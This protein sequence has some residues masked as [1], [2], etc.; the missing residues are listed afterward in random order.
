MFRNLVDFKNQMETSGKKFDASLVKPLTRYEMFFIACQHAAS[1]KHVMVTRYPITGANSIYPSK[2]HLIT[3]SKSDTYE[4]KSPMN[5]SA[6]GVKLP[7]FPVFGG[8]SIDSVI[9]HPTQLANLGGDF[10]GDMVNINGCLAD[11]VNEEIAEYLDHPR[12]M[13]NVDKTLQV[14]LSTDLCKMTFFNMSVMA[15]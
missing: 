5:P 11:D 1:N 6:P 14:G 7:H 10:D 8:S 15:S 9:L 12:Y 4:L 3:T 2:V 13:V